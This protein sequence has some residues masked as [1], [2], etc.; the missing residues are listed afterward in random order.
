ML[1]NTSLNVMGE[2]LVESPDEAIACCKATGIDWLVLGDQ[3]ISTRSAHG[4]CE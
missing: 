3:L 1:L 2:P 4:R